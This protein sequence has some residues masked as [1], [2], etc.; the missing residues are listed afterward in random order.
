MSYLVKI[1]TIVE[2][3]KEPKREV[4][5]QG[6]KT[7]K[8]SIKEVLWGWV[9][10]QHSGTRYESPISHYYSFF[11]ETSLSRKESFSQLK[12]ILRSWIQHN[13]IGGIMDSS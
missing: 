3:T 8:E 7:Q 4:P 2:K 12:V 10:P 11:C 9:A 1:Q 6:Q 5:N 13:L